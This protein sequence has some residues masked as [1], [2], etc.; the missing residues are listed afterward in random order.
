MAPS[1]N[2][3]P[4]GAPDDVCDSMRPNHEVQPQKTVSPYQFQIQT[5]NYRK[6]DIIIGNLGFFYYSLLKITL[7]KKV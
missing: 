7:F 5:N 3:L 1:V 4:Q 2:S 6:G